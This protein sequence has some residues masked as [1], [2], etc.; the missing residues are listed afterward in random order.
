MSGLRVL[1]VLGSLPDLFKM[2]NS[3]IGPFHR[4][5]ADTLLRSSL[6]GLRL[7]RTKLL[8]CPCRFYRKF[9]MFLSSIW[10]RCTVHYTIYILCISRRKIG[11]LQH[12]NDNVIYCVI[13]IILTITKHNISAESFTF[14][15]SEPWPT[16]I[17]TT[18][19]INF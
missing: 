17:S 7:L 1:I 12:M 5:M 19:Y 8:P 6:A 4:T 2:F 10:V 14:P 11:A 3:I 13:L 18:Q 15:K 9:E 16:S